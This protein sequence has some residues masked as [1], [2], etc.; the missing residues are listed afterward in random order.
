MERYRSFG[1]ARTAHIAS[2][3][4]QAYI[5]L[6]TTPNLKDALAGFHGEPLS[7]FIESMGDAI[8]VAKIEPN[9]VVISKT[10]LNFL[11]ED[12]EQYALELVKYKT[13]LRE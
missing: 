3:I 12:M 10:L 8:Y 4:E 5:G 2:I 13:C 9:K 6:A 7:R 11:G 1:D